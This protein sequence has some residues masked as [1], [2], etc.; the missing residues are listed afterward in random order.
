MPILLPRSERNNKHIIN[1][2]L[3]KCIFE[4]NVSSN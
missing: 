2:L 4:Y 3:K 1:S